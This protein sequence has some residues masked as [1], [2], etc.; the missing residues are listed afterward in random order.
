MQKWALLVARQL[1]RLE[2]SKGTYQAN[3]NRAG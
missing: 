2:D 1:C 3:R